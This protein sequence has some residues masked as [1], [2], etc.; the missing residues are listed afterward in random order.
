MSFCFVPTPRRHARSWSFTSNYVVGPYKVSG[1]TRV[2]KK[3]GC[4]GTFYKCATGGA[5]SEDLLFLF[6]IRS[7][8]NYGFSD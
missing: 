8:G 4:R 7:I 6:F 3:Y 5:T 1:I 2:D